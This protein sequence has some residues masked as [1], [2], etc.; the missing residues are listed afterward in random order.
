MLV[1]RCCS[2]RPVRGEPPRGAPTAVPWR[3]QAASADHEGSG[4]GGTEASVDL[5]DGQKL[6]KLRGPQ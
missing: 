6:C 5:E 4:R 2:Q 1:L 3:G